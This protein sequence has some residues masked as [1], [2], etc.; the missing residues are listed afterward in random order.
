M[1]RDIKPTNVEVSP[2]RQRQGHGLRHRARRRGRPAA[3]AQS[4]GGAGRG[5]P[6][7]P[8]QAR[9]A[10]VDPRSDLYSAACVLF[11]MSPA[12]RPSWAS[13]PWRSPRSTCGTH[14]PRR[15]RP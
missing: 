6:L 11:E 10:A 14:R 2:G 13:P 8:E 9:G 15:S 12:A 7:S 1:R 5:V 4:Q 3:L